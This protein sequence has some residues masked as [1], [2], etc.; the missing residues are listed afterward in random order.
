MVIIFKSEFGHFHQDDFS[1]DKFISEHKKRVQLE[2][3][4]DDLNVY[5]NVLKSAM[6][7]LINKDYA[8]FV[9]LSSNLVRFS[10]FQCPSLLWCDSC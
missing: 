3:V 9:N 6:I 4:R 2:C 5:L 8:D 10:L 7:E 1:V